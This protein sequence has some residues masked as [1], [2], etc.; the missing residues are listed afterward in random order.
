M[1][2]TWERVGMICEPCSDG[3]HH[4]HCWRLFCECECGLFDYPESQ[5]KPVDVTDAKAGET[6]VES[7]PEHER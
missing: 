7:K 4:E 5:R 6:S 1:S 3:F 2:K